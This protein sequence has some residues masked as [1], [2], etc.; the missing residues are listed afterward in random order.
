[1]EEQNKNLRKSLY[2]ISWKVSE[3]EYRADPAFS[4]STLARFEREGFNNISKL[5]DKIETPSLTF[6][7]CVDTILTDGMETFNKLFTVVDN[8]ILPSGNLVDIIKRLYEKFNSNYQT[9]SQIPEEFILEAISDISWNN[10]WQPKTRVKKIKED[11]DAYYQV[12]KGI[13]T[14]TA[15]SQ[16]DYQDALECVHKLQSSLATRFYFE[17]NSPF[18]NTVERFYQLKFKMNFNSIDF[19]CMADEIIVLHDKKVIIPVDLKTSS[20]PEWDFYKSFLDWRYDIQAR[21]YWAIINANLQLDS[22]FKDFK[23]LNYRFI[24][25]N[26]HTL[27]PLV[28]EFPE[29]SC[30]TDITIGNH[31]LRS[32][33]TIAKDLKYY[34]ENK[35]EV[36]IDIQ[37]EHTNSISEWI[38]K[39]QK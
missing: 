38:E 21:L 31:K 9:L 10:H 19:R 26:R 29:T 3:A 11:G 13:G 34:L 22:Y 28:W 33:L 37:L 17:E 36:P 24:V 6:G 23:L 15:V 12:L 27:V 5:F 30:I 2:A 1:M 35:P 7:S 16:K 8:Y 32:P 20:K 39:E 25:V 18:D 4:Y 14:K